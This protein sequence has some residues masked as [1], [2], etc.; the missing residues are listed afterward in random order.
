MK[1]NHVFFH[2]SCETF[3]GLKYSLQIYHQYVWLQ[4]FRERPWI[5]LCHLSFL[6]RLSCLTQVTFY[7]VK[8]LINNFSLNSSCLCGFFAMLP[9][10][11]IS[12][13]LILFS[14]SHLQIFPFKSSQSGLF[15][16]T[17]HFIFSPVTNEMVILI[18]FI[19]VIY[20]FRSLFNIKSG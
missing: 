3:L 15:L 19:W 2:F 4:Y 5:E 9:S 16:L 17:F 7:I 14:V 10:L 12:L 6:F 18:C 13:Y 20:V 1:R 11:S 8:H